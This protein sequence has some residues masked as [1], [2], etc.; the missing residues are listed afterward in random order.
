MARQPN[1]AAYD[2][3]MGRPIPQVEM[4]PPGT[5][6]PAARNARTHSKKQIVQVANSI[7][8]FGFINPIVADGRDRVIASHALR[9]IWLPVRLAVAT[10]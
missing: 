8:E 10:D 4:L 9:N 3:L 2:S 6:K 5:L 7:E 1:S